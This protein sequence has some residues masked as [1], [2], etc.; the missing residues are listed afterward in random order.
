MQLERIRRA[1]RITQQKLAENVGV[2]QAYI[3]ALENGKK[4]NPSITVVMDIATALDVTVEELLADNQ[5]A[6]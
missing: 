6:G 2:T 3:C 1:K 4:T 5:K